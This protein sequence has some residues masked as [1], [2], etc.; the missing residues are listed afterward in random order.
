[1]QRQMYTTITFEYKNNRQ[2]S[3][4]MNTLAGQ[5][6]VVQGTD[7]T[8]GIQPGH[9]QRDYA[10][11]AITKHVYSGACTYVADERLLE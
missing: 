4:C 6:N 11:K 5:S 8:G 1:M 10:W 2:K 9:R 3:N 7:K